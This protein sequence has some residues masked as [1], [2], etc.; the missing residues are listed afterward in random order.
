MPEADDERTV[1][2]AE[3]E[4]LSRRRLLQRGALAGGSV[5]LLGPL[6]AFRGGT[7]T[8]ATA[9]RPVVVVGAGLAGLTCAHRLAQRGVPVHVYEASAERVGG[10]CW[11]AREFA[12]G[13]VG[14]HGGELIDTDHMRIRRL[15]RELGL[16]LEDLFRWGNRRDGERSAIYLDGEPRRLRR[17][18]HGFPAVRRK[19]RAQA[20]RTGYF[21]AYSG[22]AA[23]RFDR[24]SVAGWIDANLRGGRDSLLGRTMSL[25]FSQE[26][27]LDPARLSATNLFYLLEGGG[28]DP[29]SADGS[30]ER[31]H[32]RGGND[33]IPRRLARRLPGGA[34]RMD[35]PLH[36]LWRR[37][38]GAYGMR[39]GGVP[40]PVIADRIVLAI[41]FTAL[42]RVDLGR[43]GL[44]PRKRQAIAELGMGT[45]SKLL[46]QFRQ[47]PSH[48]R[49]WDG[50]LT[51][52]RPPLTT[53]DSTVAQPG[54][55]SLITVYTG[56]AAGSAYPVR[57]AHGPA[58]NGVV[59]STLAVLE[60]A[61]PGIGRDFTGRAWLDDWSRDPWAHGSYAAFLPGQVTEF[62]AVIA[63]REGGLH[64]A[65]EHTSIAY[66]G[67]LEGAVESG[68]RCAREVAAR[69]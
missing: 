34:L 46:M 26:F 11:T 66:Q 19:L 50:D 10:R 14:E 42:R 54:R 40:K 4:R 43:S 32:V 22:P 47:R 28:P 16:H 44:S 67:F 63:R 55:T 37:A 20:R 17:V 25:Y 57:R 21:G 24:I 41:P 9:A 13:Q 62:G 61:A 49:L 3:G 5:V 12:G 36:A 8:A 65:G 51:T 38:D 2:R 52:D 64:F 31:F 29:S 18:V 69:V 30:D 6:G 7:S 27:G 48:Y 35:A 53:W 68:E 23:R 1:P 33:Q 58:P 45:N 39:F 56:G 60:R 15:A 59:R